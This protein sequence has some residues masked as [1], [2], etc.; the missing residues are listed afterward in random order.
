MRGLKRFIQRHQPGVLFFGLILVSLL[1]LFFSSEEAVLRPKDIGHSVVSLGQ[2]SVSAVAGFFS[3]TFNSINELRRIKEDHENALLKLQQYES[4]EVSFQELQQ[5]NRQLKELLGFSDTLK[6]SHLAAEVVGKDPEN[7]FTTITINKGS[8][9]GIKP[10]MPVVAIQNGIEGLVGKV[11][12]TGVSSSLIMPI[13]DRSC[14]VAARLLSSR[15][16]GL[17]NGGGTSDNIVMRY[18]K[19]LLKTISNMMIM[20][21]LQE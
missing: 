5:E 12:S 21:L 18:V 19:N 9:A 11:S 13:F 8:M 14:F 2:E 15:Y 7:F 20:S 17:L 1:M 10:G 6:Y 3:R 4:M 16:E